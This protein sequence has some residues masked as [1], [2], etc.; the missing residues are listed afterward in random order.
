M[1]TGEVKA[2]LIEVL[3]QKVFRHQEARA[4]VTDEVVKAF[5]SVR[6]LQF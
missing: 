1:L 3:T 4:A 2:E 6:P 5:M